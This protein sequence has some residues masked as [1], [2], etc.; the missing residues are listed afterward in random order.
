MKIF[1]AISICVL[2]FACSSPKKTTS[3]RTA[4][5]VTAED[6]LR[7][8]TSFNNAVILLVQSE[9]EVLDEEYKWLSYSYPKYGLIKR[10]HLVREN[11]HFD[12]VRIKT[13]K[14]QQKD[15]Y[16]DCTKFWAK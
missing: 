3:K 2:V 14:G 15:V 4:S 16:F 6:L 9:R 10:T 5:T 7:G 11:R 13:Q 1:I 8:G 12:I